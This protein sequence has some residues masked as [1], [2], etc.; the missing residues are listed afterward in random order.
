MNP[1]G[2]SFSTDQD[3]PDYRRIK[4][5][6]EFSSFDEFNRHFSAWKEHYHH[7]FRIY[8]SDKFRLANGEVHPIFKVRA[9]SYHCSR[10]GEPR[11]RGNNPLG[12]RPTKH[13]A[14]GCRAGLRIV[15]NANGECLR[16][17]T[18][19]DAHNGH[20]TS[21]E[22]YNSIVNKQYKR[23]FSQETRE[24]LSKPSCDGLLS[25]SEEKL[26]K[27]SSKSDN[28]T[29]NP[30]LFPVI[31]YHLHYLMFLKSLNST[32]SKSNLTSDTTITTINK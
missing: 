5:G 10:Y 27:N 1:S 29:S 8:N 28:I 25:S 14:C 21:A 26:P 4:K 32:F 2:P 24:S 20:R 17:T 7:P 19:N 3:L 15:Y 13:L 16:I 30:K 23:L 6:A 22:E 18:F 9:V 31:P 12:G 11:P